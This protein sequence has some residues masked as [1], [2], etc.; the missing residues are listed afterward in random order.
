MTVF[1]TALTVLAA[2]A[3]AVFFLGWFIIFLGCFLGNFFGCFL[4]I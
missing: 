1:L 4:A 2:L 3:G